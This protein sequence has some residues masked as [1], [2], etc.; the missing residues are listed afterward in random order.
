MGL[1]DKSKV[2]LAPEKKGGEVTDITSGAAVLARTDKFVSF[3][4]AVHIVRGRQVIDADSALGD[5]TRGRGAPDRPRAAGKR[6]H[7]N[8]ERAARR[9]QVDVGRRHQPDVLRKH[10]LPA[11]RDRH[12]RSGAADCGGEGHSRKRAPRRQH[13]NR[14]GAGRH[15]ADVAECAGSRR[16]RSVGGQRAA[17]QESDVERARGERRRRQRV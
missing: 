9:A 17:C 3:E 7:R 16:V 14:H 11:E 15:D 6:A 2:K 4:R 5:L 1:S 10:R 13:R 12:R 8:A